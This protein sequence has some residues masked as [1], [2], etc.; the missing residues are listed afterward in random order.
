MLDEVFDLFANL[1]ADE[2]QLDFPVLYGS[3]KNGWMATD[4]DGPKDSLEPLFDMVIKHVPAPKVEEGEFR[5]L[6]TTIQSDNFLGRILTGRIIAGE[7][8]PN[9][10]VK[11]LSRDGSL[12]EQGRVSKVLAF[13]GLERAAIE[14]GEAGDIVSI[15]GLQKGHRC[16]HHLR[17]SRDRS[18]SGPAD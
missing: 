17:A 18:H 5:L 4:P 7:V 9:M 12:I 15:A 11:A 3:A 16:R 8:T 6:A 10:A 1:D 2:H 13:R 14:K